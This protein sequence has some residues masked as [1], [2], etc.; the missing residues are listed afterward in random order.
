MNPA[1]LLASCDG[2]VGITAGREARCRRARAIGGAA[3][4]PSSRSFTRTA[5]VPSLLT[6]LAMRRPSRRLATISGPLTLIRCK[7]R[8]AKHPGKMLAGN[9]LAR[10][11]RAQVTENMN[12][13]GNIATVIEILLVALAVGLA[14]TFIRK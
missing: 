12:F 5:G 13:G 11:E 9:L 2:E 4:W 14:I 1:L 7:L 6:I 8:G 3:C 10:S